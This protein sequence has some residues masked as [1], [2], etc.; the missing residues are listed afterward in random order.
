M[1][2]VYQ[3]LGSRDL[4]E[5]TIEF[6]RNR[7]DVQ[8][9]LI[10]ARRQHATAD[11][12][13]LYLAFER[14]D[15]ASIKAHLAQGIDP[16]G[17]GFTNAN[18][19][20][21]VMEKGNTEIQDLLL[22]RPT[23][24]VNGFNS[25]G[26]SPLMMAVKLHNIGL[27]RT[28]LTKGAD[29]NLPGKERETPF[30]LAIRRSD[31]AMIDLL[32]SDPK[33]DVNL[34]DAYGDSPL[35]VATCCGNYPL[36]E[37]LLLKSNIDILLLD[38]AGS[39]L[40]AILNRKLLAGDPDQYKRLVSIINNKLSAQIKSAILEK[41]AE[42]IIKCLTYADNSDPMTVFRS[43]LA[44]E[45]DPFFLRVCEFHR[46]VTEIKA[47][48]FQV[49][50]S[51]IPLFPADDAAQEQLIK[52]LHLVLKA[53]ETLRF[54]CQSATPQWV[55][56]MRT[57]MCAIPLMERGDILEGQTEAV[58]HFRV[59]L[60]TGSKRCFKG[61]AIKDK[62]SAIIRESYASKAFKQFKQKMSE[63]VEQEEKKEEN[64]GGLS[65]GPGAPRI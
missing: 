57:N 6:L 9:D 63:F 29:V 28:L 22:S 35:M 19:L 34:Q 31:F 37:K 60:A 10:E 36:V 20:S 25:E 65:S 30:L 43:T 11:S 44:T 48:G 47:C 18:P 54:Q 23:L 32:L 4:D 2:I 24:K 49:D 33:L 52:K 59:E 14:N 53:H 16:D 41:N 42:C 7:T 5:E 64:K 27:V 13:G 26:D 45:K 51:E 8:G 17:L 56:R 38:N 55:D 21:I 50:P 3:A 61:M 46:L 62:A 58:R 15:S 39:T 1:L 40:L 12:I